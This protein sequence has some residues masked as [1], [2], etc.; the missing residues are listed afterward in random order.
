MTN[1]RQ[2]RIVSLIASAT[3][4]VCALDRGDCLV[5]RSHECDFPPRVAALPAITQPK[6]KV[7]GS[8]AAIDRRVRELVRNGLSVYRV[9]AEALSALAPDVILTQDHCE[10]CAV[11]L[12]DVEKATATWIDRPLRIVSLR[13]DCLSDAYADIGRVARAL[14]A[15]AAGHTLVAAID[16]RLRRLAA[17]AAGRKR[18]RVAFIEWVEPLMAGGNWMPEL[19]EAAGGHNLFGAAGQHSRTMPWSELVAADPD[20]IIVA[21]CGYQLARCREE[22]ALLEQKS[23]WATLT[24]VNAGRVYFADGN[25]YFNR[26]GPRLA[27]SGEMLYDMLHGDGSAPRDRAPGWVRLGAGS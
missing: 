25:A 1:D 26:P 2:P 12:T 9:D 17:R 8:S 15:E 6:F 24:A 14:G 4:I 10:V 19:I 21:P 20:V 18:P 7:E 5:G 16:H 3:E 27:D 23:G 11:S 13:P 22:L